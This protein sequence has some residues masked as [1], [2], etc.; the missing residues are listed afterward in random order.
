MGD[1][2]FGGAGCAMD[3]KFANDVSRIADA[4]ERIADKQQ[5]SPEEVKAQLKVEWDK[6][7]DQLMNKADSEAPDDHASS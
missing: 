6:Y 7:I 5:P 1:G 2:L 4:L 3:R